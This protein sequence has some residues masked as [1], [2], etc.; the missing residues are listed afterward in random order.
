MTEFHR[1]H[2]VVDLAIT[3][4]PDPEQEPPGATTGSTPLADRARGA[5]AR[6]GRANFEVRDA[7]WALLEAVAGLERTVDRLERTLELRDHGI[8]LRPELVLVGADGVGLQRH[9][10]WP[11]GEAVYVHLS[12]ELREAGHLLALHGVV[13]RDA[14][15]TFVRFTGLREDVRDLL[16]AFV[17]Q[18]E[19]RER[20]RVL[21][22][23]R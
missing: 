16:V 20:R 23:P 12:L 14:D 9:G 5:A 7:L 18:Q 6:V 10:P 15:G 21:D 19:A 22:A 13:E 3:A 11:D 17:F 2:A 1:I 4:A 8:E